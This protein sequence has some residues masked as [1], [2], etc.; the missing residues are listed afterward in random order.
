MSINYEWVLAEWDRFLKMSER[1]KTEETRGERSKQPVYRFAATEEEVRRQSSVVRQAIIAV[2]PSK[3]FNF[4][5]DRSLAVQV[6][7]LR[8]LVNDLIPLVQ[9]SE[10]IAA[11]LST[12]DYGPTIAADSL[13]PWVWDAARP[14]WES[15]NFRAAIHAAATNV[16]SRLR[17]KLG[18]HDVSEGK[19]VQQAFTIEDPEINR[20]RLRLAPKDD[21]DHFRSVQ[22]GAMQFG[23]GLFSAV[24]NPVAHLAD[25]DHDVA[26]QEALE[27]L[28]AFSLLSRWIDRAT[29]EVASTTNP[30]TN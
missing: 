24:R 20:P 21:P 22:V 5:T 14:H 30:V 17:K 4:F 1:V 12:D 19:A 10:E 9:R 16:N 15:G 26:E 23:C 28:T 6:K 3:K 7:E 2:F 25:D 29:L 27:S 18:R 13:H 8:E 11:N